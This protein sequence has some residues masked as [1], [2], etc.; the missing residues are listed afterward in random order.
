MHFQ[1]V[2][3]G[4]AAAALAIASM[5][6]LGCSGTNSTFE[7]PAGQAPG[8]T[9]SPGAA[10]VYPEQSLTFQAN[11]TGY[12]NPGVTWSIADGTTGG[13]IS[14]DGF[15]TAPSS[16]GTYR[17]VATSVA[18]PSLSASATVTVS[19]A[20]PPPPDGST[21][22][23][24]HRTSGVAPLAVFF[25]AID[26]TP[27]G[28]ASP[29]N[30]ASNVYQPADLEGAQ[31]TWSFGDPGSGSWSTTGKSKNTATGYTAAHVFENPGTYTVS[32][33]VV[34]T[35]GVSRT[36]TQT[37]NV[38]AFSG[39]TFFVAA[40]GSDSNNGTSQSTPFQTVHRAMTAALAASGPVQVLFR[41]GD[42][43]SASAVYAITKPGPGIIGAY[44][45]GNRPV[46]NV[47]D[48]G[49]GNVFSPRGTGAD[50]RI[51]DLD[52]RGA[53][54]STATGPI[55]PDVSHQGVNLLVLRLRASNFYVGLGWGDWT[56]IYATP[57]DGMFIVD[58]ESP[59]NGGY[60]MY[61][62]GRRIALLGNVASDPGQTHVC[63]VWQAHKAVISNNQF[64]R[65]GGQ[66]HA[67]KL[68]GPQLN[69]G[70]PETRWVSINDN[71][72][73]ASATSQWTV[74]IGSAS[75]VANENGPVSHLVL[76]RNRFGGSASLVADIETE[77]SHAMVRNNVFDD[78]LASGVTS[79]LW[80][81]RNSVVPA[82][83]DIRIYNNTFYNGSASGGS[84]LIRTNSTTTNLRLRNNLYA[85]D[86][87][88]NISL[89][90]GTRGAGWA[91][92]VNL[93]VGL[94]AL[95]NPG[96]GDFTLPVGSPAVDAGLNLTDVRGD[97]LLA[98][99]PRGAGLDV[100][101]FESR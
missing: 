11:V 13:T 58:S 60:G 73:Q 18:N 32:L 49:D 45:S 14:A 12:A 98:P 20:P 92:D 28:S 26:T 69:D 86:S 31:Y 34:D 99:R 57:H 46:I 66:R 4:T 24:A 81:Q 51:M 76:E 84:G 47:A 44:G 82:P 59:N 93:L 75:S 41:R 91:E 2:S 70:R 55:G 65:P 5:L 19:T 9:V 27:T 85:A 78:T 35:A 23:A 42:T 25:D 1:P 37:I 52:M 54:P 87:T 17:V 6:A 94:S 38:S 96:G 89:V 43:F 48:M 15:Y 100:G 72:F 63:R 67:L 3:K 83:S 71:V 80:E 61:L 88:G 16:T 39:T 74:S 29:F 77:S 10:T 50:W 30:W 97:Y 101:A 7:D 64:L 90:Q 56:P 22:T 36:Y 79:I 53:N 33:T 40:N 21:M 95:A 8:V 68:H 62:G